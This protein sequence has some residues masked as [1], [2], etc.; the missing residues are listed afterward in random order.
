M[1]TSMC[2]LGCLRC[3]DGATCTSCSDGFYLSGATCSQCSSGSF[4]NGTSCELCD[5]STCS[6][7]CYW[8]VSCFQCPVN[9]YYELETKTCVPTC[10]GYSWTDSNS[11]S[12]CR[13]PTSGMNI[14][15][16][17][18]SESQKA[19]ELGTMEYPYKNLI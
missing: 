4:Y 15:I 1:S 11:L 8:D 10:S 16:H 6:L 18:D 2:S 19:V 5:V 13:K 3:D 14:T 9:E 12:F 7:G 17:L